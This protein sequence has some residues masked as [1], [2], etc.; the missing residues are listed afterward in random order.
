MFKKKDYMFVLEN[1]SD[2]PH[3]D[4]ASDNS[5]GRGPAN[6]RVF[7]EIPRNPPEIFPNTCRQNIFHTY[8]GY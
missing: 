2:P 7:R 5:R 4:R 8:L 3:I 1:V 6:F